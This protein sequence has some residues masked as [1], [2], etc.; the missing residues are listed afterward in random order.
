MAGIR[1][2]TNSQRHLHA[3]GLG[4][5]RLCECAEASKGEDAGD[6][7]NV[8]SCFSAA[9]LSATALYLS[10]NNLSSESVRPLAAFRA[11]ETLSLADNVIE[12]VPEV[13]RG[14]TR[15]KRLSLA[16][17]PVMA[18]PHAWE[19][20]LALRPSLLELNGRRVDEHEK[21]KARDV[22]KEECVLSN[23][24]HLLALLRTEEPGEEWARALDRMDQVLVGGVSLEQLSDELFLFDDTVLSRRNGVEFGVSHN[25]ELA[26]VANTSWVQGVAFSMSDNPGDECVESMLLEVTSSL[27]RLESLCREKEEGSQV[28]DV[29]ALAMS[30][31]RAVYEYRDA[32]LRRRE[33]ERQTR[34]AEMH[35]LREV[36][37]RDASAGAVAAQMA[38]M[39]Q[40]A[41]ERDALA[42]EIRAH[43][44]QANLLRVQRDG[45][46]EQNS[47]IKDQLEVL[48]RQVEESAAE[49]DRLRR[50][51]DEQTR[52]SKRV[53][54]MI[55]E[56]LEASKRN[57][58]SV[59]KRSQA[60]VDE[61][62]AANRD[63]AAA[64]KALRDLDAA[65]VESQRRHASDLAAQKSSFEDVVRALQSEL[66]ALRNEPRIPVNI[67]IVNPDV[68]REL[69]ERDLIVSQLRSER[70]V[71]ASQLALYEHQEYLNASAESYRREKARERVAIT[72]SYCFRS[73]IN[74]LRRRRATKHLETILHGLFFTGCREAAK[75]AM[76]A[77]RRQAARARLASA[78]G[79][80]RRANVSA[81]T[82]RLIFCGW[83]EHASKQARCIAFVTQRSSNMAR[84]ALES[85][86]QHAV[87]R[88][89][90]LTFAGRQVADMTI[91]RAK[92]K[93]MCAWRHGTS[94]CIVERDGIVSR[95]LQSHPPLETRITRLVFQAWTSM[96][97][98]T[99]ND[100]RSEI[101]AK[102]LHEKTLTS[103]AFRSL[104]EHSRRNH[105]QRERA[106]R[107]SM[108]RS[109]ASVIETFR[110][111][112]ALRVR[113]RT[114]LISAVVA[115]RRQARDALRHQKTALQASL[116]LTAAVASTRCTTLEHLLQNSIECVERKE[117][118]AMKMA[119]ACDALLVRVS[120]DRG[121]QRKT[122]SD[123]AQ[124][125]ARLVKEKRSLRKQLNASLKDTKQ[126]LAR[127]EQ[128][129][130]TNRRLELELDAMEDRERRAH[131]E[132]KHLHLRLRAS[133]AVKSS[134][135]IRAMK[136]VRRTDDAEWSISVGENAGKR[137]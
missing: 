51:L 75:S 4:L 120:A 45:A 64:G 89:E 73:W 42:R 136:N 94:S 78:F 12:C 2:Q 130:A 79:E 11:L 43:Q 109:R 66:E 21:R 111:W 101:A 60:L 116:F 39:A 125:H 77:W 82:T 71:I 5:I 117:I 1:R 128:L 37:T 68:T 63:R 91:A 84:H 18:R 57:E 10:K 80:M 133:D 32:F 3:V 121:L 9:D 108:E 25:H 100:R 47:L 49:C 16:G 112:R 54:Q 35:A 115:W 74:H 110:C 61:L 118:L 41:Q 34:E 106:D 36:E 30:V 98:E 107:M 95:F 46:V 114:L 93:V 123:L 15:L 31:W 28:A 20:I 24:C 76:N 126:L 103:S 56:Q 124:K 92:S 69:T 38:Q 113:S 14:M 62:D 48:Q 129:Q 137:M 134:A 58:D 90:R 132:T 86:A 53:M 52:S 81:E 65:L 127:G 67:E 7:G 17:N 99:I 131:S 105:I 135:Q 33:I 97:R 72:A 13:I 85:L 104:V 8:C 26:V 44:A 119:A 55:S 83:R 96:T 87:D 50:E 59:S 29:L 70:E 27:V 40:M 6:L 102:R 88:R 22:Y 122:T 23:V 19:Q